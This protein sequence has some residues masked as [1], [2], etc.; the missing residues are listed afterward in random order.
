[1]IY[2]AIAIANAFIKKAKIGEIRNLTPM[3]LQKLMFFAQSWH[4]KLYEKELFE[5]TFERWQYGH[6]LPEIYHEFKPFGSREISRLG[7]DIWGQE[8]TIESSDSEVLSFLDKII[9]TYGEYDG[10]QLSWM[11]HQPQTA[12]SMGTIGT[13]ISNQDLYQGKV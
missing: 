2:P 10:S 8:R 6:V 9:Q 1:M 7:T 11:T 4:C 12:W 3:K 13:V 5:G